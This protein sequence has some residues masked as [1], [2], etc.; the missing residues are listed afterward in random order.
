MPGTSRK[1]ESIHDFTAKL[2][3][4]GMWNSVRDYVEWQRAL[5]HARRTGAPEP[6]VPDLVPLSINLDLTTACNYKCD[7]CIDWDIL[8][9]KVRYEDA[10]LRAQMEEMAARGMRSV[11]LI[12]GGEPTLY[13]GFVDF[14][15]YLKELR[16]QVSVVTNGSRNHKIL[17]AAAWFEEG[18]WVRLSLDSGRN[19][20]FQRMHHPSPS[21]LTLDEIC[22]WIPKIK[23]ANG[24]FQIGYSFIITW[25]GGT[26]DDVKV[27]E[28]IGEIELAA[29]RASEAGFDY[30]SYKPFLERA[31]TGSEV[32]DP[33]KI[34]GHMAEVM[35][36][37]REGVDAARQYEGPQFSVRESTNLRM[38]MQNSWRDYTHQPRV[39]HMQAL[40]QVLSPHGMFNCPAYR[41]VG[42][43]RI[44]DKDVFRDPQ[45]VRDA[46]EMVKALL[47]NFD[48]RENC[49]DVTCLYNETNWWLER[50][51]E[52]GEDLD[53]V[54]TL[55]HNR[56]T[57]L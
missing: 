56:D 30:I 53:A 57:F 40:R 39:C 16:L 22:S 43:A 6:T 51:I 20:T 50:L 41:G 28:N 42:F 49:K 18:D 45:S 5:R 25:K 4:Q 46:S 1:A 9:A 38:L 13:P 27:V 33:D 44:G 55:P 21:T 32:M 10:V 17:E 11:I 47:D 15:R 52:S 12:G 8:N 19:D 23:A 29:K 24:R 34:E 26:R 31:E 36:R 7:H 14:V 35:R 2:R 3:R 48:A 54:P 37:I